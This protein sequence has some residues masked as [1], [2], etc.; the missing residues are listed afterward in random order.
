MFEAIEEHNET[1]TAAR[2]SGDPK[3]RAKGRGAG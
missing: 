3:L 1:V 2:T